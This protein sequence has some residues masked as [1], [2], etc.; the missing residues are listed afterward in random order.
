MNIYTGGREM[1]SR[2]LEKK[3]E[4]VPEEGPLGLKG[5]IE[6]E[7]YLIESEVNY[8]EELKGK[9]V[10][11]IEIVKKSDGKPE[12]RQII[13]NIFCSRENTKYILEKLAYNSVTPIEL[14]YILDDI[15]GV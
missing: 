9:K 4:L 13:R 15:I 7:Y 5:S 3:I 10:Y 11:G 14:P 1:I 2:C 8:I 6:L 12:E